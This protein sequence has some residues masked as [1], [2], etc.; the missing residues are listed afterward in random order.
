MLYLI[1]FKDRHDKY[2]YK[3]KH[4]DYVLNHDIGYT[5]QY[6]QQIVLMIPITE[7]MYKFTH[8]VKTLKRK[9]LRRILK[10]IEKKLRY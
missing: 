4:Y 10:Y 3:L 2:F 6:G 7:E 5:T 8:P 1:I 9:F